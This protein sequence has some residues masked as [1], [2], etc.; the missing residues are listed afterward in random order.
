MRKLRGKLRAVIA[1]AALFAALPAVAQSASDSSASGTPGSG[2]TSG[3]GANPPPRSG[4]PGTGSAPV[5]AGE[6]GDDRYPTPSQE[7]DTG[8]DA[9]KP[10]DGSSAS[11]Q[12]TTKN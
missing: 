3:P 11:T 10:S 1:V 5:G 4:S 8:P 9:K 12:D 7:L 2:T 6:T